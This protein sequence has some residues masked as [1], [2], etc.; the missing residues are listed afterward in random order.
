MWDEVYKLY[1]NLLGSMKKGSTPP[2]NDMR[3]TRLGHLHFSLETAAGKC[4]YFLRVLFLFLINH[5]LFSCFSFTI[6]IIIL[7]WL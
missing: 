2:I 4:T 3:G 5:L 1:K 6:F 7:S